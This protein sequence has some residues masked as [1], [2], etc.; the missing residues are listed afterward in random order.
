MSCLSIHYLLG[1][2]NGEGQYTYGKRGNME[3]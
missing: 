1:H 3:I 2:L